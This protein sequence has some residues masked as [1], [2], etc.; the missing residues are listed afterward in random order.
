MLQNTHVVELYS[1]LEK[2]DEQLTYYDSGIGTFVAHSNWIGL[3]I[4]MIIHIWDMMVA[5][6]VYRN[7]IDPA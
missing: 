2:N 1:R 3:L 6:C 7:A 5:W 4:Q